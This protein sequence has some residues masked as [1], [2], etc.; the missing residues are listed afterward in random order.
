M[1]QIQEMFQFQHLLGRM[2]INCGSGAITVG[3]IVVLKTMED[4]VFVG[5]FLV[6]VFVRLYL[7]FGE[8]VV[9]EAALV[10]V[11]ME[12]PLTQVNIQNARYALY[13][14]KLLELL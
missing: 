1:F 8:A 3:N 14:H 11:A 6:D 4:S 2:L 7:K 13:L 12:F 5:M 10:V 9:E